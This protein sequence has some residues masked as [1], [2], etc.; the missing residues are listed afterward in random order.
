MKEASRVLRANDETKTY[1]IESD[2]SS[3]CDIAASSP[4]V[5]F[6]F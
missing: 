3:P 6:G 4:F 5:M 1:V 2:P